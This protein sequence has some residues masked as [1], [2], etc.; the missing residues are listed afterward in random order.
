MKPA[1]EVLSFVTS[2]QRN[3]RSIVVKGAMRS[4]EVGSA[5]RLRQLAV[6]PFRRDPGRA[7][8]S[9]RGRVSDLHPAGGRR[10]IIIVPRPSRRLRCQAARTS[11]LRELIDRLAGALG[12][13]GP[14]DFGAAADVVPDLSRRNDHRRFERRPQ[15]VRGTPHPQ[16]P[17][18]RIGVGNVLV[19][20]A[21]ADRYLTLINLQAG[22]NI[23]K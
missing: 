21:R 6:A 7:G 16:F 4:L 22:A 3:T 1:P 9:L 18:R 23:A 19:P 15:P 13:K 17:V 10:T 12:E 14:E 5:G 11:L 20:G 8:L 2:P